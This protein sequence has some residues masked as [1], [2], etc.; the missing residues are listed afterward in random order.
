MQCPTLLLEDPPE[1]NS[2]TREELLCGA[3]LRTCPE[4]GVDLA[5]PHGSEGKI[6]YCPGCG[7]SVAA[8]SPTAPSRTDWGLIR[9]SWPFSDNKYPGSV[10]IV[11]GLALT[12]VYL[13]QSLNLY[14]RLAGRMFA[15]SLISEQPSAVWPIKSRLAPGEW[16]APHRSRR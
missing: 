5:I 11:A 2:P 4:C 16:D 8:P 13:I 15:G 6:V 1:S 9:P 12:A 10:G 3:D 14:A 7:Q